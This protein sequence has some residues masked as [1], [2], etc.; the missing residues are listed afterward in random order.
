VID[1]SV[2][3]IGVLMIAG[4]LLVVLLTRRFIVDSYK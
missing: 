2:N 3:A 1:P 4:S